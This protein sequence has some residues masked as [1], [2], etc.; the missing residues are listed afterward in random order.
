MNFPP[1]ALDERAI[2]ALSFA[3]NRR[4]TELWA[5]KLQHIS[6]GYIESFITSINKDNIR[7]IVEFGIK[8]LPEYKGDE[9]FSIKHLTGPKKFFDTIEYELKI[10]NLVKD[11]VPEYLISEKVENNE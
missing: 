3:M 1:Y 4:M 8:D 6:G 10:K 11:N 2:S 5:G 9:P 7:F